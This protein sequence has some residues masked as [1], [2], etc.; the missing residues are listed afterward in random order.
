MTIYV[1]NL[2]WNT[3]EDQVREHFE[4]FGQV[5]NVT[6]LHDRDSG[7]FR[8][9]GFVEMHGTRDAMAAIAG[10]D[11]IAFGGRK[12]KVNEAKPKPEAEPCGRGDRRRR[13]GR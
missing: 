9:F 13:G 7:Q 4:Q 2:P 8:G 3:G 12:L 10:L 1:G 6:L 11:G 5:D